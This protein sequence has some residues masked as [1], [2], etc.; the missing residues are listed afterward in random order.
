[1]RDTQVPSVGDIDT[2]KLFEASGSATTHNQA[3]CDAVDMDVYGFSNK[4]QLEPLK[5]PVTMNLLPRL[6]ITGKVRSFSW[7]KG[8]YN[9]APNVPP[10]IR[11]G[12][13]L[14]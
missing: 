2:L 11:R 5:P 6:D 3:E 13:N 7:K 8:R 9:P 1:M 4:R 10:D 12:A 14:K